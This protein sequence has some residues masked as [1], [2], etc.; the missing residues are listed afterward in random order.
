[1]RAYAFI[2]APLA[3]A[4]T[5]CFLLGD[6]LFKAMFYPLAVATNGHPPH[7]Y[8]R[9]LPEGFTTYFRVCLLAGVFLASPYLLYQLW[10]FIAAGLY[11][12]ERKAVVR[13]FLP[14]VALFCLGVLFF[15]IVVSPLVVHYFLSF[16]SSSFPAAPRVP[17]WAGKLVGQGGIGAQAATAPSGGSLVQ[18]WLEL[19]EYI[20]FTA[21]L[22]LVFGLSF[23][24]PLV[25]IFLARMGLVQPKIL[26]KL[27]K[28]VFFIIVV[29][30][31]IIT[32]TP[33][34]V[35]MM[36]MALPMYALYEIGLL[37]AVRAEKRKAGAA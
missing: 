25:V 9:A 37:F 7:L 5:V 8:V 4:M 30:A 33:D 14:S 27:R 19:G 16:S 35:T 2:A 1:M 26:R 29:A 22:S 20:S 24:T 32:P 18:P 3:L 15:Y 13:F 6:Y 17:D 36:A 31:A 21:S 10:Q 12:N 28:H 23:Q 11:E 34:A